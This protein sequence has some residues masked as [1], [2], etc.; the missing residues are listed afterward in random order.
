M[1]FAIFHEIDVFKNITKKTLILA[2]LSEAKTTKNPEQIV[3]KTMCFFS[4]FGVCFFTIFSYF[5]SI[6]GGPG[7][8]KNQLKH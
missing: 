7:G 4:I 1:V 6:L 8:P 5:G 2:T 3:L